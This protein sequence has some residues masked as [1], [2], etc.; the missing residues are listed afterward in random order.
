M[1]KIAGDESNFKLYFKDL[2]PQVGWTT[3]RL[4]LIYFLKH[5]V[6]V[7]LYI[8]NIFDISKVFLTEYAGPLFI[9]LI[10]YMRPAFIYSG[11]SRFQLS[12]YDKAVQ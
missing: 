3:V 6:H 10:F 11:F 7:F 2:G 1:S 9:Y 5:V 4:F 12:K 8:Y